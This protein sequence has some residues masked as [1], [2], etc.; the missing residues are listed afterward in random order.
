MTCISLSINIL[1]LLLLYFTTLAFVACSCSPPESLPFMCTATRE[2]MAI[3]DPHL[4]FGGDGTS[5]GGGDTTAGI[6]ISRSL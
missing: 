6:M 5:T 3:R 2:V 4:Y 1:L